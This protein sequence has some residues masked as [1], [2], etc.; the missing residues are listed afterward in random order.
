MA[1]R[2]VDHNAGADS[3]QQNCF[4]GRD[5]FA[6]RKKQLKRRIERV[7]GVP[8]LSSTRQQDERDTSENRLGDLFAISKRQYRGS[9]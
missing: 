3:R 9:A 8:G 4:E 7:V 1:F 2:A 5:P 6:N